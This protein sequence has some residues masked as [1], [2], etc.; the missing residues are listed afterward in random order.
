MSIN[1]S[2]KMPTMTFIP[3]VE[4]SMDL[5]SSNRNKVNNRQSTRLQK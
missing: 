2:K 5:L 3:N 1:S 4:K